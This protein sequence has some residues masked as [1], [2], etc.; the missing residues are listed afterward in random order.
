[1][2]V[3][4]DEHFARFGSKSYAIDKINSVE[5]RERKPHGTNGATI[6][7]ILAIVCLF[8]GIN[9]FNGVLFIA[10]VLFVVLTYFL[11][12]RSNQREYQLILMTSSSE[13][14]AISSNERSV[15][16]GLRR[17]IEDAMTFA[18]ARRT[19]R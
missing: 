1:M 12:R 3:T 7:A 18:S 13:A 16:D 19:D 11:W 10:A 9:P 6:C 2:A 15:I 4:I 17:Q 8:S 14:E 5:V